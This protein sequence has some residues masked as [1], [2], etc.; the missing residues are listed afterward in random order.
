MPGGF[1]K[2]ELARFIEE[3]TKENNSILVVLNTKRQLRKYMIY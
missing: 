2:E 3:T 1:S